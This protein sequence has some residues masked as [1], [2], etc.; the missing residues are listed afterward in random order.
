M[1]LPAVGACGPSLLSSALLHV[2]TC[3]GLSGEEEAAAPGAACLWLAAATAPLCKRGATPRAGSSLRPELR[4]G[5]SPWTSVKGCKGMVLLCK[6]FN[7]GESPEREAE[8]L[9]LCRASLLRQ[10]LRLQAAL[11]LIDILP[12]FVSS[13]VVLQTRHC[14]GGRQSMNPG[15]APV[16]FV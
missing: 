1:A 7:A 13:D 11:L 9:A 8:K 5:Q 10:R 2:T 14:V 16:G 4:A 15:L 6:T 3:P 12:L